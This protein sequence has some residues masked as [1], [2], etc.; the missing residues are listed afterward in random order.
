M[1]KERRRFSRYLIKV[2]IKLRMG[3]DP[4]ILKSQTADL[5]EG[6][7]CFLW[8]HSLSQGTPLEVALPLGN[9]LFELI[10]RV[11][12]SI[13]DAVQNCFRTGVEFQD[14][15]QDFR[16]KFAEEISKMAQ[17]REERSRQA[18][19]LISDEELA[20]EWVKKYAEEFIE[21]YK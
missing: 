9:K 18:G 2:P 16:R 10:G 12:Y 15:S 21:L 7:L 4:C 1:G 19:R 8:P 17:F 6:G 13:K 11:A 20:Q 3:L 14:P 5:S